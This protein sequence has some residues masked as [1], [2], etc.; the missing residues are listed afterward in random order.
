M[1]P[2]KERADKAMPIRIR[3]CGHATRSSLQI[4]L[5]KKAIAAGRTQLID[6]S[7]EPP[8]TRTQG[9]RLKSTDT[10]E[11]NQCDHYSEPSDE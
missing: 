9:P 8:G 7:G 5:E 11:E 2:W 3:H 10:A 6:L 4:V 1:I